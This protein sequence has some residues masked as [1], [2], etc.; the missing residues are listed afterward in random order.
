MCWKTSIKY[1]KH[2]GHTNASSISHATTATLIT[3][4]SY[5]LWDWIPLARYTSFLDIHMHSN[6][7]IPTNVYCNIYIQTSENSG[8]QSQ[9]SITYS[10]EDPG[11][12]VCIIPGQ[13]CMGVKKNKKLNIFILTHSTF[14]NCSLSGHISYIY[15]PLK[16]FI[17]EG[18]STFYREINWSILHFLPIIVLQCTFL[19]QPIN[20][21]QVLQ[22][23]SDG[24]FLAGPTYCESLLQILFELM[25]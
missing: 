9:F 25:T 17:R 18:G 8:A 5:S 23:T 19:L 12:P 2:S 15:F 22:E 20:L 14:F 11:C 6:E 24:E 21:L 10:C 3:F 13:N 4:F 7:H 16:N 1:R